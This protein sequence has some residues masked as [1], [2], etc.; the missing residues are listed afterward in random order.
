MHRTVAR[1]DEPGAV[2]EPLTA[3]LAGTAPEVAPRLLGW[4]LRHRTPDGVVE[5]RLTEVEAY[6]G[7]SD[8]ASHA[9]RGPTPRNAV[10]FGPAGRLYV[11]L[12]YGTHWCANVV[13]G[14]DGEAAAVLLR[15]GEVT[16]GAELAEPGAGSAPRTD[17]WRVARGAWDRPWVSPVATPGQTC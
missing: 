8:P 12:S 15:A 3:T 2:G 4:T 17:P 10:M 13:T 1:R 16:V 7:T 9:F 14:P 6:A 11:Y 5:V